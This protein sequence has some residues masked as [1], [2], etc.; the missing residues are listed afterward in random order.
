MPGV[1]VTI[2]LWIAIQI[3]YYHDVTLSYYIRVVG[4][5][6]SIQYYPAMYIVQN[7]LSVCHPNHIIMIRR[8]LD[9]YENN[10]HGHVGKN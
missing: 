5:I 4:P 6:F 7:Y 1:E 3:P 2:G 10:V 8:F 9:I